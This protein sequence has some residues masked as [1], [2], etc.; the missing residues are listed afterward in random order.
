M[1]TTLIAA[2][3]AFLGQIASWT[4]APGK[5]FLHADIVAALSSAGLDATL[6][7]TLCPRF[8]FIRAVRN[9]AGDRII[10]EVEKS[11]DDVIFQLDRREQHGDRLTYS[12]DLTCR[13][14]AVTGKIDCSDPALEIC[15]RAEMAQ[16]RVGRTLADLNRLIQRAFD[17]E[18]KDPLA[19]ISLKKGS[20]VYFVYEQHVAFLDRVE[21]FLVALG[22]DCRRCPIPSG[23]VQGDA[24]VAAA[25]ADAIYDVI[26]KYEAAIEQLNTDSSLKAVERARASVGMASD[27]I[28]QRHQFLGAHAAR[29]EDHLAY[30]EKLFRDKTTPAA[31]Q[32]A[33]A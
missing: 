14:D 10:G 26:D 19:C 29:L 11:D 2:P 15:L 12:Y 7:R 33:T 8:E 28:F 13:M 21:R 25:T 9:L 20:G 1:S 27:M 6:A 30:V 17:R 32:D 22:G 24:S 4:F 5:T 31:P 23:T 16:A 3:N 18:T